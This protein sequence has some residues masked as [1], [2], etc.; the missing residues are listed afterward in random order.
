[1]NGPET[2]RQ[3]D[4]RTLEHLLDVV[5]ESRNKRCAKAHEDAQEQVNEIMRQAHAQCR[6]RMHRHVNILREKYRVRSSSAYAR[7]QTLLRNQHQKADRAVLDVAWPVLREAMQALWDKP[8]SR[9]EWVDAAIANASDSLLGHAWSVEYPRGINDEELK[10][11]KQKVA[12][13]QGSEPRLVA[14]DDI[15]AGIRI[16]V[17]GTVS[18][19]TLDGLLNQKEAIEASMIARIRREAVGHD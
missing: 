2:D 14:K 10:M 11:L 7:N 1:M 8:I 3:D 4:A 15:V 9:G 18:D 13:S 12:R 17:D 6:K 16:T 19:A 5:T